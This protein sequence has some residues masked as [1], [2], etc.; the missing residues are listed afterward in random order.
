VSGPASG[1]SNSGNRAVDFGNGA[2]HIFQQL[3]D[4]VLGNSGHTTD[5]IYRSSFDES[6]DYLGALAS[7]KAI[8]NV[9]NMMLTSK[10]VKIN[11]HANALYLQYIS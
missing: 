2:T 9:R 3:Q 8:H 7:G 10:H 11:R 6:R 1:R 4:G 5:R